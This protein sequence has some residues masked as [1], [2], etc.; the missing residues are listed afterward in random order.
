MMDN[1]RQIGEA[2]RLS[3]QNVD[4]FVPIYLFMDNAGG[5]GKILVKEE[6][7]KILKEEYNV[8]VEWQTSNSP[9]L[10]LLDLGIWMAIQSIVEKFHR[11]KVVTKDALSRSVYNAFNEID[12]KILAKVHE[13]WVKVLD[14][15]VKGDGSND[16]V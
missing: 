6:Y 14:L 15:I 16:L 1:I 7:S 3:H 10:N 5:H 2:V 12:N 4:S 11:N 8:L 9:E 13:R